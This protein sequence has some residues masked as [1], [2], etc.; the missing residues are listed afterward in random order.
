MIYFEV[1][2]AGYAV[3]A[4]ELAGVAT[5]CPHVT[6]PGLPESV[7]GLIHW[8]GKVFPVIDAFNLG[9][10]D[11][12]SCTFLFSLDNLKGQFKE[13]AIAVPD[14]VRVFFVESEGPA[15]QGALASI[16]ATLVDAEGHEASQLRV[17]KVAEL[18]PKIATP[19]P[20]AKRGQ[21]AK[22]AA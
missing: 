17:A 1:N 8:S 19:L 15:P 6:Y 3:D 5:A 14:G 20:R 2:G 11:F 16:V 22:V 4:A 13:I 9:S 10:V 7:L 18:V 21:G 12:R